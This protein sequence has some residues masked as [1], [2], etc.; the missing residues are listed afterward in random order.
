[1]PAIQ[2]HRRCRIMKRSIVTLSG[3]VL[4]LGLTSPGWAQLVG[5]TSASTAT[6]ATDQTQ[7]GSRTSNLSAG[8]AGHL[9]GDGRTHMIGA[10]GGS[11]IS[12]ATHSTSTASSAT[13]LNSNSSAHLIGTTG[14]GSAANK[15]QSNISAAS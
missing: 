5:H 9:S 7:I 13:N 3:L 15:G 2:I 12:S 11:T 10:E 8:S 1:M 6:K 14:A 4:T